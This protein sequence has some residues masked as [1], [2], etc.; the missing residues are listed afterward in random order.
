[1]ADKPLLTIDLQKALVGAQ[2][3]ALPRGA[4]RILELSKDPANGPAEYAVPIESDPG[5]AG[6]V[7]RFVNSSYFG[8]AERISGITHAIRLVGVQAIKTFALW[9]TVF[10]VVPNPK[11]GPFDL[12]LLRQDSLRRALFARLLAK[13]LA[14]KEPDGV[15]SAALL[16]DMAVP[17]LAKALPRVYAKLLEARD[18]GQWRLSELER[19]TFGWTHAEAAAFMARKWRLSEDLAGLLESHVQAN[20]DEPSA[21]H[22]LRVTIVVMSALLPALCDAGWSDCHRLE[23]DYEKIRPAGCASLPELL[24]RTD[25]QFAEFASTANIPAPKSTLLGSYV[26]VNPPPD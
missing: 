19:R 3:P 18:Q 9:G 22:D 15:F 16:Q 24:G 23:A 2:L 5:L 8:F 1:V 14:V 17:L 26:A 21:P 11:C 10:S 6:Q 7:L 20:P 13:A 4:L 12:E 25:R